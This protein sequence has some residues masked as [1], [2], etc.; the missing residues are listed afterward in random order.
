MPRPL[1][2]VS[3]AVALAVVA[4]CGTPTVATR[5]GAAA[6]TQAIVSA[7]PTAASSLAASTASVMASVAANRPAGRA[8]TAAARPSPVTAFAC[9]PATLVSSIVGIKVRAPQKTIHPPQHECD[10]AA[11]S[12]PSVTAFDRGVGIDVISP[13]TLADYQAYF[14]SDNASIDGAT[15]VAGL[16][17]RAYFSV[18]SAVHRARSACT[19][20][21]ERLTSS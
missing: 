8:T 10:Y 15:A 16:G 11:T 1:A 20:S 7:P 14:V 19:P 17:D 12:G 2:V 18:C 13:S 5:T 4:V 21:R 3:G 6:V 9:P